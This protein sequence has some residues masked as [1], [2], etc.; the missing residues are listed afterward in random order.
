MYLLL[1]SV[2]SCAMILGCED[3]SIEYHHQ[4]YFSWVE[5]VELGT[6]RLASPPSPRLSIVDS[7]LLGRC[8]S[9][10]GKQVML[11]TDR[12]HL[13]FDFLHRDPPAAIPAD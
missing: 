5:Q 13:M 9:D 2:S 11:S 6:E 12:V 1:Q 8:S 10:A 4:L 7:R 3:A